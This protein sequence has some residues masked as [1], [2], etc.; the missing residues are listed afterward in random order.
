VSRLPPDLTNQRF[1]R[2]TVLSLVPSNQHARTDRYWNCICEC[3]TARVVT[4]TSLTSG[5][6]RSCGCMRQEV[7]RERNT[8]HGLSRTP[9]Y[10]IYH[11]M[12][13]R[14]KSDP[15]YVG[16]GITVC[17]RWQ[18]SFLA[19]HE[20]MGHR[21]SSRHTI[22]RVDNDGAYSPEN[23]IWATYTTQARN[24]RSNTLHTYKGE[25]L[26]VR[27]LS[28]KYSVPWGT[29]KSRLRYGWPVEDAIETPFLGRVGFV[30]QAKRP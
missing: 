1:G 17:Q 3:G 11:A 19:F 20:D 18:D 7:A 16:R 14:C 27:E 24:R 12:L 8:T 26:T 30:N 25:S 13:K 23:C 5:T 22:E 15:L 2:L 6:T 9:E 4:T 28:E 21:P 10:R 29:L